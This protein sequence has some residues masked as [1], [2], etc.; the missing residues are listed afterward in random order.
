MTHACGLN[1]HCNSKTTIAKQNSY[2]SCSAWLSAYVPAPL[3]KYQITVL[4]LHFSNKCPGGIMTHCLGKY[5]S[6]KVVYCDSLCV[7]IY[8]TVQQEQHVLRRRGK[9]E[10]SF[11]H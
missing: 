10:A 9:G 7:C 1:I 5:N 11:L 8:E 3:I 2:N 6:V 4:F